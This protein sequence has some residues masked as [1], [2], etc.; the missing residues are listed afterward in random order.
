MTTHTKTPRLTALDP[1]TTTGPARDL[2]NG[3]KAQLGVTPNMMRT[4]ANSPAVLEGYLGFGAALGRGAL[5]ATLREQIAIAVAEANACDYCLFAHTALGQLAGLKADQLAA[6]RDAASADPRTD[7]ALKFAV[8]VLASRGAV[9]DAQF[10]A[11]RA[12]GFDEGEIA[13]ILAHV[14][15]NVFTNYFNRAAETV[16][17]F[18]RVS[19]RRAA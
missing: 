14:A 3:V 10:A 7:A 16:V 4:M 5:P 6:S 8:A 13:E 9:S 11:V 19:P 17:D 12:A 15:I 1:N 2:L 18:P